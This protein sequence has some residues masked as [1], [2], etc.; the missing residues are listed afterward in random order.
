MAKERSFQYV[1]Y[2]KVYIGKAPNCTLISAGTVIAELS[3]PI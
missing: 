2:K 1:L 3:Q